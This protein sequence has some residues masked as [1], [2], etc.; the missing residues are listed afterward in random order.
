MIVWILAVLALFLVQTFAGPVYQYVKGGTTPEMAMG[1]RDSP[2]TPLVIT[3]RLNRALANMIEAIILFLPLAIL[4]QVQGAGD[5][6]GLAGA[7]V[8]FW[9]RLFYVPAYV[10]AYGAVR[11][12]I[13][14]LGHVGLGMM[15]WALVAVAS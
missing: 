8:F 2:G 14:T 11:S 1:P 6:L 10:V 4:L 13:W 12:L 7:M 15:V 5:G 9:A 3:G